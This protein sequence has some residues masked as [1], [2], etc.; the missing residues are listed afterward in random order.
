M[1][2]YY[3]ISGLPRS[4]STLLSSI[5]NQ[6]KNFYADISSPLC[7]VSRSSISL[8]SRTINRLNIDENRRKQTIFGLFE[9]YYSHIDSNIIFDTSRIWT[10]YTDFLVSLF[11]YTKI[12]CCVRDIPS[13]L[14]SFE[15]ITKKNSFYISS[16]FDGKD[17]LTSFSRC[18]YLM[19]KEDGIVSTSYHGLV[20]G[21]SYNPNMIY[22]VNYETLCRFP[23]KTM[24]EIYNFLKQPYFEHDFNNLNYSNELVD[25]NCNTKNLH[26]V[27]KQIFYEKEKIILP[28]EVFNYYKDM[29][30][31]FWKE[32]KYF[33]PSYK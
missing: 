14:N 4:G 24:K 22:F 12:L 11:P 2:T 3:F 32:N 13:V 18:E 25:L 10:Y 1:K 29:K 17:Y 31:E 7:E 27:K 15:K 30:L 6:N 28:K 26:T 5:L 9:G 20:D 19:N 16:I 8:L 33:K 23:K 21:Y